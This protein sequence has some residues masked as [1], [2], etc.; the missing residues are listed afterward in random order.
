MT[1]PQVVDLAAK[2]GKFSDHWNPRII[3]SYNGNDVRVSK[4]RGEFIWHKHAG[5]DELFLV[6]SG[7]LKMEF[8]DC[9]RTIK[10]GQLIIV[11]KGV[12]HRPIADEECQLIVLDAEGE[13]NTGTSSS[14]F[15]RARLERI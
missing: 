4:V 9:V 2:F 12:E 5:T 13:S 6:W 8:R 3:G 10:A 1:A 11:P 14:T 15:T 7:E